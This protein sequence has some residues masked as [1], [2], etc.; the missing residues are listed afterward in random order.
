MAAYAEGLNILRQRQRRRCEQHDVDAETTP[1]RAPELLPVRPRPG[2]DRRGVAARQRRRLLAARPHRAALARRPELDGFQRSGLRLGRG[3]LDARR[4]ID[5]GV[6]A[7]VLSAA[8]FDRFSSRGEGDFAD[9]SCRRCATSSAATSR[10]RRSEGRD[11]AVSAPT[12]PRRRLRCAGLLRR[13]RR[14][15]LQADLPG[16]LRDGPPRRPRRAGHRRRQGRAGRSTSSRRAPATAR[17]STASTTRPSSRSCSR[18]CATSTATTPTRRT[19]DRAAQG[20]SATPSGRCTTSPSR[21]RCSRTVVGLARQ[22]RAAPTTRRVVVEKPFGRDLASAAELNAHA[23]RGLPRGPRSSASTTTSAR[24]AVENLL[25]FRFANSFLEPIWNRNYVAQRADH[26][27]RGRSAS[28]AA[29]R[30]TTAV[31]AIR[32]V[33]QNHLLQV[34]ALLAMEPPVGAEPERPAATRRPSV[35]EAMRPLDAGDV[36]R[37]QYVGYRDEQGVAARLRRRDLRRRARCTSTR[38]AGPAC[39]SSSAP[40]SACRSPRPRCVVQLQAAAQALFED[41][42]AAAPNYL[43]SGS[44]PTSSSRSRPA[45][46]CRARRMVGEAASSCYACARAPADEKPP[47]ERLLGD[48]MDG[49]AVALR[50]PGRRRGGV[51][52]RRRRSSTTP[53]RSTPTSRAPGAR[54]AVRRADRRRRR[55]LAPA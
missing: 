51:A 48:A 3:P 31:G 42:D 1:L 45:A 24:S 32:D 15:R 55:R 18:C 25:V 17:T 13:H 20:R 50:P 22:L 23:A 6:P 44:A 26:D 47:Y 36:V 41:D 10:S 35:L 11:A 38:G 40:A 12:R 7:P 54:P 30:S 33:V 34:V 21:R 29:A 37:G 49:D 14:P 8:L 5:E 2:R 16:A 46:R 53:P 52:R 28:R 27:G 9:Q 4:G 43:A 19:F 39:R